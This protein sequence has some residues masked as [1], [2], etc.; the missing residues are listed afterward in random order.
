MGKWGDGV[1]E[2]FSHS[3][4]T[5]SPHHSITPSPDFPISPF[6]RRI[7]AS[8][9]HGG[10]GRG[11]RAGGITAGGPD[12]GSREG[13]RCQDHGQVVGAEDAVGTPGYLRNLD[14]RRRDR[15]PVGP[16]GSVRG[17]RRAQ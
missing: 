6:S 7:D 14:E 5:P 17:P 9:N 3:S 10:G 13:P 16:P 2:A 12:S 15:H 11:G 4:I 1:M 8:S